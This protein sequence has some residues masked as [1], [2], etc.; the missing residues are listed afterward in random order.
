MSIMAS[1]W[2]NSVQRKQNG[3]R[4]TILSSS[5]TAWGCKMPA[6]ASAFGPS[7]FYQLSEAEIFIRTD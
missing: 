4:A 5:F 6:D 7:K 1:G 2:V 3:D